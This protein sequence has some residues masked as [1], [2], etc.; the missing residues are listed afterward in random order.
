MKL[1]VQPPEKVLNEI[2]N[3]VTKTSKIRN[4]TLIFQNSEFFFNNVKK[5]IGKIYMDFENQRIHLKQKN[6]RLPD[7]ILVNF[8]FTNFLIISGIII[9]Q[10]KFFDNFNMIDFFTLLASPSTEIPNF[11]GLDLNSKKDL[12]FSAIQLQILRE[13][14]NCLKLEL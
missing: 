1:I 7:Y 9:M 8:C 4:I 13:V 6:Y 3:L 12:Y 10:N 14:C 2:W 5:K 11:T